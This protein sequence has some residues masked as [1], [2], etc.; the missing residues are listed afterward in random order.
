MPY[1]GQLVVVPPGV[2]VI[3]I[4][5]QNTD[6]S[7]CAIVVDDGGTQNAWRELG[8][9]SLENAQVISVAIGLLWAA[10][11][12]F[13]TVGRAISAHSSSESE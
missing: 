13:K 3:G 5:T 6:I 7:T 8:N 2:T 9:L 12:G 10:A 11:W 4:D 1:C